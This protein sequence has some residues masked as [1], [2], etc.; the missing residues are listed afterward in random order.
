M[1]VL[2][3]SKLWNSVISLYRNSENTAFRQSIITKSPLTNIYTLQN[4]TFF[5]IIIDF[6]FKSLAEPI[7]MRIFA[8][9]FSAF[10]SLCA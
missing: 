1:T 10:S 9:T 2:K 8:P 7:K 6:L 3:V 5:P 4:A